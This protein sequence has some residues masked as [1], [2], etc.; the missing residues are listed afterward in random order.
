MKLR[1]KVSWLMETVQ[2]SLFPHLNGCLPLPLTEPE[3]HLVKFLELVRYNERTEAMVALK[4]NLEAGA[5]KSVGQ[6]K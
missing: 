4:T 1:A 6:K 2:Q 3:K 5:F